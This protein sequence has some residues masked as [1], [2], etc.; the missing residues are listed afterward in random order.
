MSRVRFPGDPAHLGRHPERQWRNAVN[1]AEV[2]SEAE[3]ALSDHGGSVCTPE[4]GTEPGSHPDE[5]CSHKKS[6]VQLS[7]MR[8]PVFS[9]IRYP[10]AARAT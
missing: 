2:K 3:L 5:E 1:N 4:S 9:R 10:A 7:K 6:R 8:S